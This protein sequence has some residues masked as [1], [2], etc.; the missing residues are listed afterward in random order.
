MA[1]I[2]KKIY[3]LLILVTLFNL[4]FAQSEFDINKFSNPTKYGW[5][6]YDDR[7]EF[8]QDLFEKQK[9]LQIY[10]MKAQSIPGNMTKSA[11]VPGWG[12][13]SVHDYTKGQVFLGVEIVLLGSSFF[14]YDKA[15]G[16]YDAYKSANQVDI[17]EKNYNDALSPYQ[18][19]I[20]LLGL[21]GIVWA[22]NIF[23]TAESTENYNSRVWAK[24]VN[25]SQH[26][27]VSLSPTGIEV[28]F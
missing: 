17:I 2:V 8:R 18:Y 6:N 28:K 9:L 16:K 7:M 21:F 26:G 1:G 27:K 10:E 15:M 14:L 25:E 19:S 3:L 22:Y 13:F 5:G 11:I 24:T 4:V 23:D 20:A 12:H